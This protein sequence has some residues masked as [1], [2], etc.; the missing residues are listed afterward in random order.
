MTE[1]IGTDACQ[2]AIDLLALLA[3][4][5]LWQCAG[6]TALPKL[7]SVSTATTLR[8]CAVSIRQGLEQRWQPV[9]RALRLRPRARPLP[10]VPAQQ[11]IETCAQLLNLEYF[12]PAG[13]ANLVR[14]VVFVGAV[15]VGKC[16]LIRA[17][18]AV[19]PA[20]GVGFTVAPEGVRLRSKDLTPEILDAVSLAVVVCTT[21]DGESVERYAR[22][23]LNTLRSRSGTGLPGLPFIV[24]RTKADLRLGSFDECSKTF[25]VLVTLSSHRRSNLEVLWYEMA[26]H[27]AP[28]GA[29]AANAS[30][31]TKLLLLQR[32]ARARLARPRGSRRLAAGLTTGGRHTAAATEVDARPACFFARPPSR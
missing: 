16:D 1:V 24:A 9:A 18:G 17:L 8:R 13:G 21:L 32:A 30:R 5:Y 15:G 4:F 31:H 22:R 3:L 14:T 27:L 12:D 19:I 7:E 2:Y 6:S 23:H 29:L 20:C 11:S 26:R 25:G 28:R 10:P